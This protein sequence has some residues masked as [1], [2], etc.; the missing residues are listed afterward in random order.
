MGVPRLLARFVAGA[1]DAQLE[2]RFGSAIAQRLLFE[3]MARAFQPDAAEG[4]RGDLVYEL[5]RPATGGSPLR[6]TLQVL[7]GRA[8][9]RLG[10][11]ADPKLTLRFQ[12][13]DFMRMIAGT[14]DPAAPLLENRATF[15]GDLAL[16]A[17]LPEMFGAPSSY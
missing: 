9:A 16:A 14:I 13:S 7:D 15:E 5:T 12:L 11:A 8:A 4:F 6:W 1:S 2:H 17:R 10:A 3:G